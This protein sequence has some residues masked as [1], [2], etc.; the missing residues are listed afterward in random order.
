MKPLKIEY[1]SRLPHIAPVGASFFV[2]FRMADALPQRIIQGLKWEL[3][4][5]T[6]QLKREKP[7]DYRQLILV[8]QKRFFGKYDYQLDVQ[9]FGSCALKKPKITAI[10]KKEL[11]RYDGDLYDLIAYSIMPNHVHILIDTVIQITDYEMIGGELMPVLMDEIPEEFEEL[12][13]I[14]KSIKGTSAYY[15]NKVLGKTGITFWQKDSYDHYIRNDKEWNN[16]VAYILNNP[17]K[18]K[19]V[20]TWQEWEGTYLKP[21]LE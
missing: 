2:T 18:A 1:R 9:P 11:H 7:P 10:V 15:A 17:V 12:Y 19:F 6:E 14:M 8:E 21:T 13:R 16:I 4:K 3:E 20:K 5:A